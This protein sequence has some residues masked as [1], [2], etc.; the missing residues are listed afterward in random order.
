MPPKKRLKLRAK[1]KPFKPL[2]KDDPARYDYRACTM[3]T[4]KIKVLDERKCIR[5]LQWFIQDKAGTVTQLSRIT[6]IYRSF[7]YAVIKQERRFHPDHWAKVYDAM[8]QILH[9]KRLN[10]EEPVRQLERYHGE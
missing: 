2:P 8:K 10:I 5:Q 4:K 1:P 7:F 6:K 9:G 3:P